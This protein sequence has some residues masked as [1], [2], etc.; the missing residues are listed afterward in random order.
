MANLTS[1]LSDF[2]AR[3]EPESSFEPLPAGEYKSVAVNSE[4]KQTSTGGEML[5]MRFEVL[6]G[7]YKGRVLFANFN[8]RNKSADAVRIARSEFA[9]LCRAANV[10]NPRDSAELHNKP[11][12]LTVGM[13]KR[14]DTGEL[15]N[16]IKAYSQIGGQS[17]AATAAVSST[18]K[19]PW[20]N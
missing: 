15:Q 8:M 10:F 2:D 19:A 12:V 17:T 18:E 11:V 13:E 9:S 3:T 14:K 6:D 5:S 7:Q 1:Y 4:M 20:E 16:R